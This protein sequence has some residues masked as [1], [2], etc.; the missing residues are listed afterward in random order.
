M[1]ALTWLLGVI[2]LLHALAVTRALHD[3]WTWV[4][5]LFVIFWTLLGLG[6][7][8][9]SAARAVRSKLGAGALR[10]T[11]AGRASAPAPHKEE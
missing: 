2:V 5:V 7:A 9:G 8:V 4:W 10:P 1:R 6:L 3:S 11:V